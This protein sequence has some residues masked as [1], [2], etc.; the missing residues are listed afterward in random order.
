[1]TT[2][3]DNLRALIVKRNGNREA[4]GAIEADIVHDIVAN[5]KERGIVDGTRVKQAKDGVVL[6][7]TGRV[8]LGGPDSNA[9]RFFCVKIKQDGTPS[10]ASVSIK[11]ALDPDNAPFLI[12]AD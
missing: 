10:N 3:A 4:I 6:V 12:K 9:V 1:M 11:I 5:L 7:F 2:H 8:G